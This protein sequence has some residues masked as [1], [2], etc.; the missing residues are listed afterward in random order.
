MRCPIRNR[1]HGLMIV[2]ID[3]MSSS[4]TRAQTVGHFPVTA[5]FTPQWSRKERISTFT[6][7]DRNLYSQTTFRRF[8]VFVVHVLG[9]FP[10]RVDHGVQ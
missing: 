4:K 5:R 7:V 3:E 1:A 10:H 2:L 6:D 8:L 9:G